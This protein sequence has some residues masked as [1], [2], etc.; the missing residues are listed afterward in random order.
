MDASQRSAE[1]QELLKRLLAAAPCLSLQDQDV[2]FLEAFP[3]PK[4][5][6]K[7]S[8][9]FH[10][11]R[12]CIRDIQSRCCSLRFTTP[13]ITRFTV[14]ILDAAAAAELLT[15]AANSRVQRKGCAGATAWLCSA[16]FILLCVFLICIYDAK[17]FYTLP[18][19]K[20]YSAGLNPAVRAGLNAERISPLV[21]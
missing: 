19:L 17:Y 12:V 5:N 20:V 15:P 18:N 16:A 3:N 7:E 6:F 9:H 4:V 10:R 8:E 13:Y 2:K 21:V 11:L 1:L 14:V